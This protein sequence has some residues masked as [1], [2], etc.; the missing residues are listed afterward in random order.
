[1]FDLEAK[2]SSE[3]QQNLRLAI[4]FFEERTNDKGLGASSTSQTYFRLEVSLVPVVCYFL[5][6]KCI[7]TDTETVLH[8]T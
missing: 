7:E 4:V 5:S 1:M 8:T 3:A 6:E 2:N